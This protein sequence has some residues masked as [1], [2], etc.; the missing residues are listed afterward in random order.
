MSSISLKNIKW[1]GLSQLIRISCQIITITVLAKM[2][3]PKEYGIMAMATVVINFAMIIRDI[4]F[5]SAIIQKSDIRTELKNTAF[6]IN[7]F[8]GCAI[9]IAVMLISSLVGDFFNSPKLT[10]ILQIISLVFPISCLTIIHQA[11]FEKESKFQFLAII[12]ICSA[13]LGLISAFCAAILGAG[14]YSLVVQSLIVATLTSVLLWINSSFRPRIHFNKKS[15]SELMSFGVGIAGFNLI[16]YF[17]RNM[18][19]ILI[20]RYFSERILGQYSLA[21][22][23]MLFPLQS[24]TYVASRSLYPVL[25]KFKDDEKKVKEIYL[26]TITLISC[27]TGPMMAGLWSVRD[28]FINTLF[29]SSWPL[30]PSLLLWLAPVAYIQSILSITGSILSAKG[31]T[32]QLFILGFLGSII[33]VGSFIIGVQFDVVFMSKLYFYANILNALFVFYAVSVL[34]KVSLYE[35]VAS[36]T[37][38]I[39]FSGLSLLLFSFLI[40]FLQGMH[41]NGLIILILCFFFF[42]VTTLFL[43][44][45]NADKRLI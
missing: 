14:V 35:F 30:V 42:S 17:S 26:N 34:L 33:H 1:V 31:K 7:F 2:I 37:A 41:V 12:E 4:G 32:Y 38:S 22:R 21:Y 36:L 8:V 28:I 10:H 3:G 24:M 20:G 13:I 19:S 9:C 15:A 40:V 16:N 6:S 43:I 27:F 39:V 23:I 11:L 44:K 29:G 45:L 5:G 18:D 25:S